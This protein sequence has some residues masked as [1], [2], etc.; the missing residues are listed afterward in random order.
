MDEKENND[1]K[2]A[3]EAE[4]A[5]NKEVKQDKKEMKQEEKKEKAEER[6]A[7][8]E[9]D[10]QAAK[11]KEL[12]AKVADYK[13]KYVRLLAEFDNYR[14]RTSKERLELVST[15]GED[16]IKGILP[17][18]DDFEHA[19]KVLG[20]TKSSPEC[21][22]GTELIYQKLCNYLKGRGV[23]EI[24]TLG[25]DFDTDFHEAVAQLP[26]SEP[27]QK[28]KVVDVIQK[29]YTLNGKIIRYAKV[30]IAI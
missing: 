30:V 8:E 15:A 20:E 29:G 28:N 16:V 21:I 26:A 4:N 10:K 23:A 1:G 6:K 22:K 12:D 18:L 5:L 17:V 13:D 27:S 25:E 24:K 11:I 2:K 9:A 3:N 19:L 7:R 14:R